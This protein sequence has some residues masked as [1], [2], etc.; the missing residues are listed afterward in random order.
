MRKLLKRFKDWRSERV[1]P[2][3]ERWELIR[4]KGQTRYVIHEALVLAVIATVTSDFLSYLWDGA[5]S[6][7]RLR[8]TMITYFIA[9]LM[10]GSTSWSGHER[11][12]KKALAERR[13]LFGHNKIVLR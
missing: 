6:L 12:Y 1:N 7:S 3:P 2:S 9:G 8:I 11:K 5:T 10:G 4:A 13:Q